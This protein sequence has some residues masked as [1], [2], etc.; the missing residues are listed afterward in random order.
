MQTNEHGSHSLP[1][2]FEALEAFVAEW[3][4][5]DSHARMA[6]RQG[7]KIADIRRFYDAVL[8][9]GDSALAHLRNFHL[10]ELPEPEE[11]LLKLMLSLAEI[12]PAVEWYNDPMVYDGYDVHKVR[13]IRTIPDNAAQV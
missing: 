11:R 4:L 2:G 1:P 13:Y 6:K 8:P 12:G 10:G 9:L 7:G 5:P 3:A